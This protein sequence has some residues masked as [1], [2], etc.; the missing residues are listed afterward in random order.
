MGALHVFNLAKTL[1]LLPHK[2]QKCQV[3]KA[4]YQKVGG[5]AAKDQ[6]QIQTSTWWINYAALVHTKFYRRHW[7]ILFFIY[8]AKN[9]KGR[10][11]GV[12]VKTEGG[13]LLKLS[14]SEKEGLLERGGLN[15]GF[16]ILLLLVFLP[17]RCKK[18]R[19]FPLFAI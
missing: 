6:K 18:K 16:K 3:K 17:L 4:K 2:K 1:V 8:L 12:G 10:G 13:L 9:N 11:G 19:V 14:S 5:Q 15:R 7:L